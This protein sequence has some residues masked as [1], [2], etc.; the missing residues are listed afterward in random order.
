MLTKKN[1]SVLNTGK[2]GDLA[3]VTT[4][5]EWICGYDNKCDPPV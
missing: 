2:K 4:D 5:Q 3:D 1:Y